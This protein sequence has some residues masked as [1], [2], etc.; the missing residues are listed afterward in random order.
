VWWWGHDSRIIFQYR[1]TAGNEQLY[2][3]FWQREV[4]TAAAERLGGS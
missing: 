3:I 1:S 4:A 2:A